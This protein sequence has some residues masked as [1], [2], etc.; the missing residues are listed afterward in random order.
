MLTRSLTMWCKTGLYM[1]WFHIII[2]IPWENLEDSW[3]ATLKIPSDMQDTF[4]LKWSF[5]MFSEEKYKRN[6]SFTTMRRGSGDWTDEIWVLTLVVKQKYRK[7]ALKTW[8]KW[9]NCKMCQEVISHFQTCLRCSIYENILRLCVSI[10]MGFKWTVM[11][12]SLLLQT[13]YW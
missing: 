13:T 12:D 8:T 11:V 4:S 9:T 7:Y 3:G 2:G 5:L 6:N 10:L 1:D